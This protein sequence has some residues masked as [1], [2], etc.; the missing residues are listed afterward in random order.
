MNVKI[1]VAMAEAV[2]ALT[3]FWGNWPFRFLTFI[4]E[5]VIGITDN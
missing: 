1:S 3:A 4:T 5:D 2:I